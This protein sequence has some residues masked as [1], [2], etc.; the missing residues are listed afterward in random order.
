MVRVVLRTA[1]WT[2]LADPIA[3]TRS[4]YAEALRSVLA[5]GVHPSIAADIA[6]AQVASWALETGWGHGRDGQSGEYGFNVGNIKAGNATRITYAGDWHQLSDGQPYRDYPSLAAGVD[7]AV[8][9]VAGGI[10]APAWSYLVS[11]GDGT[12]WY[13]Q[14]MR[15]GYHPWSQDSLDSFTS[16]VATVRNRVVGVS[17]ASTWTL[18]G[19]L[20]GLGLAGAAVWFLTR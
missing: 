7:D 14:L 13:D 12:G 19:V 18:A 11:T 17:P 1:T 15:A 6:A 16:I 20:A 10:Y 9:L 4:R 5:L 3:W 8:R 2:G